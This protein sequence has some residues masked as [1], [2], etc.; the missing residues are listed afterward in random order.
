M[1]K[2]VLSTLITFAYANNS[3][4]QKFYK[5]VDSDGNVTFSQVEPIFQENDHVKFKTLKLNNANNAMS[6]VRTE[7]GK[8]V[9]GNIKLPYNRNNSGNATKNSPSKSFVQTVVRSKNNW[10]ESLSRLSKQMVEF[11]KYNVD[12]HINNKSLSYANKQRNSRYQKNADSNITKVRDLRCAINWAELNQTEKMRLVAI[13]H[14]LEASIQSNCGEEPI[15]DSSS[16][17]NK[18]HNKRWEICSNAKRRDLRNV[19]RKIAGL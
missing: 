8:E 19:K 15:Y 6:T 18:Q 4:A 16:D 1:K 12:S 13:S 14:K 11:S 17:V 10:K 7:F 3:V 9:C 2:I 5:A